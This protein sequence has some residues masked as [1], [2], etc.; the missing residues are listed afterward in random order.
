MENLIEEIQK[1][2]RLYNEQ[3]NDEFFRHALRLIDKNPRLFVIHSLLGAKYKQIGSTE[4]AIKHFKLASDINPAEPITHTNLAA[5]YLDDKRYHDAIS[6]CEQAIKLNECNPIAYNT[7]G[8]AHKLIGDRKKAKAKVLRALEIDKN[9]I[10]AIN[11]LTDLITEDGEYLEA[12]ELVS[13]ALNRVTDKGLLKRKG[14]LALKTHNYEAAR[15]VYQEAHSLDSSDTGILNGYA[16]TLRRIG[17]LGK[18]RDLLNQAIKLDPHDLD[19]QTNLGLIELA[20]FEMKKAEKIF[21]DVLTIDPKNINA[22][23]NQAIVKL[24]EGIIVDALEYLEKVL[25]LDPGNTYAINNK[26]SCYFELEHYKT[27][28]ELWLS[29]IQGTEECE[30]ASN[31]LGNLYSQLGKFN[32][33]KKYYQQAVTINPQFADAQ[34]NFATLLLRKGDYYN[35]FRLYE[36]RMHPARSEHNVLPP[37][38]HKIATSLCELPNKK[39]VIYIEQGLGDIIQFSRY[40]KNL[41]ELP[42]KVIFAAPPRMHNLLASMGLEIEFSHLIQDESDY[43]IPICSLPHFFKTTID[44]IPNHVPYLY[45]DENL[46]EIWRP[47]IE[48]KKFK[49]GICWQGSTNK[50]DKGRSFPLKLF[51]GLADLKEVELISLHKG[52]GESQISDCG[53]ELKTFDDSFDSENGAFSDTAAV[54]RLCDLIIT[55]DT[56]I[57]HLAG[58]MNFPVWTLLKKYPDWRWQDDG[59]T[60]PWYPSMRLFRQKQKDNWKDVFETI[61]ETLLNILSNLHSAPEK[62]ICEIDQIKAN[63][64]EIL[65]QLLENKDYEAIIRY[66]GKVDRGADLSKEFYDIYASAEFYRGYYKTAAKIWEKALDHEQTTEILSNIG[67]CYTKLRQYEN[68]EYYFNQALYLK[69]N[70]FFSLYNYGCMLS[71]LGRTFDA[72][73]ILQQASIVRPHDTNC[74]Y[75]LGVLHQAT[76]NHNASID[77]LRQVVELNPSDKKALNHLAISFSHIGDHRAALETSTKLLNLDNETVSYL[78][79]HASYLTSQGNIEHAEKILD[80]VLMKTPEYRPALLFKA[81]CLRKKSQ[82]PGSLKYLKRAHNQDKSDI[83]TRAAIAMSWFELGK[84]HRS[85]SIIRALHENAPTDASLNMNLAR[86]EL[87]KGNFEKG[88]ELY[89]HRML[90][91]PPVTRSPRADKI[92][93]GIESLKDKKIVV[94]HEQGIG[95]TFQFCRFLSHEAFKESELQFIV[96]QKLQR[97]ISSMNQNISI[98]EGYSLNDPIDYE[99]SLMSLPHKLKI[100]ENDLPFST[101]Y[102]SA[103]DKLEK[104]WDKILPKNKPRIGFCFKGNRMSDADLGRSAS[105]SDFKCLYSRDDIC[106]ILL[107]KELTEEELLMS[108][109]VVNLSDQLDVGHDGFIDTAAVISNCDLIITVDTAIAHLAG[110]LGKKVWLLVKKVPDWR[111]CFTGETSKWYPTIRIYRQSKFGDWSSVFRDLDRDIS[112]FLN[113]QQ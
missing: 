47:R 110:A 18:A 70:D 90:K 22:L 41:V 8:I 6:E 79:N 68:A 2:Y 76:K 42:S 45:P 36:F 109:K 86:I 43:H 102:L 21:N 104:Q 11:T 54:M 66:C 39:V 74:L 72:I 55:S 105:L 99:L 93:D 28:E 64:D 71:E 30:E 44:T 51:K 111:W 75:Q 52:A 107:N 103:E 14:Y 19:Y 23:T 56:S 62:K 77:I 50:I 29:I 88:F 100:S 13:S 60:T 12:Y 92:W 96:P 37:P 85:E 34:Y 57:A 35:G 63:H 69:K 31:N 101:S 5:A 112:L 61:I 53:F 73:R 24:K 46:V 48:S 10:N 7:L 49:I 9:H 89:E 67:V 1:T 97:I 58:A 17:D 65:R 32:E 4:H 82:L 78:V 91:E 15:S 108:D 33:A 40:I 80:S 94:L 38:K 25:I 84:T 59:A 98:S 20:S 95:D 81:S 83:S 106:L 26:A 3:K 16:E 87:A 113:K 27:A